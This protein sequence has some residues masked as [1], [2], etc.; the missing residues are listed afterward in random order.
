[1]SRQRLLYLISLLLSAAAAAVYA[2]ISQPASAEVQRLVAEKARL[3]SE[4]ARATAQLRDLEG[5]PPPRLPPLSRLQERVNQVASMLPATPGY[6][7]VTGTPQAFP[8]GEQPLATRVPLTASAQATYDG[9]VSLL[10]DLS[11]LPHAILEEVTLSRLPS[12]SG[13]L[14]VRAVVSLIFDQASPSRGGRP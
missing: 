5:T 8:G 10:A 1:M 14:Q 12:R 9:A 3:E 6:S 4:I 2:G 13:L 7:V 11:R